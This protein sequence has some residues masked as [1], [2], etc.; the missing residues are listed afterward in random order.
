MASHTGTVAVD[1]EDPS[2]PRNLRV[3]RRFMNNQELAAWEKV[4]TQRTLP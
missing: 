3:A 1:L 2:K 4:G